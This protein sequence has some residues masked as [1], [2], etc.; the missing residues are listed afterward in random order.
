MGIMIA[1]LRRDAG[2]SQERLAEALDFD[3]A[4]ISRIETGARK[5]SWRFIVA[6]AKFL[7]IPPE[8]LL[9]KAGYTSSKEPTDAEEALAEFLAANPQAA[10]IVEFLRDHPG[11]VS[12]FLAFARS[13]DE[14]LEKGEQD[15]QKEDH[16][17]AATKP[18]RRIAPA[19]ST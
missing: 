8:G 1:Q 17:A 9:R 3:R 18:R 11:E 2:Y 19:G 15:Q 12:R 5:P 6:F 14:L 4:Y 16:D 7:N 10:E 13:M